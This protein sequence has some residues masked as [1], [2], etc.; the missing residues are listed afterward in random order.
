MPVQCFVCTVWLRLLQAVT[1]LNEARVQ[2]VLLFCKCEH[3][4]IMSACVVNMMPVF[5]VCVG[6]KGCSKPSELC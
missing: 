3:G 5:C 6:V 1:A 4:Y 2:I